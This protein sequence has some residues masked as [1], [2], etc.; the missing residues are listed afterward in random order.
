MLSAL[1]KFKKI[2]TDV[3]VWICAAL[4]L[5]ILLL[6]FYN[7]IARYVLGGAFIYT[8]DVTVIS[9]LWIMGLGVGAGWI[10]REHLLINL[11]DNILKPRGMEILLFVLDIF[12]IGVGAGMFYLGRITQAIN[13]GLT[14]SAIGFDES[15]RYWPVV[16]GGVLLVV[17]AVECVAE[18]LLKWIEGGKK[19]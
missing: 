16:V 1:Q 15:F 17:A 9:M 7:V 6:N 12:G 8:E 2:Y 13:R 3:I 11:I 18:Q 5:G 10:N 14:Q 4:C 19:K